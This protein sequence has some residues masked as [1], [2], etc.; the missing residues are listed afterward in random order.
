MV[1]KNMENGILVKN[2]AVL[3]WYLQM[4]SLIGGNSKIKTRKDME[5]SRMQMDADTSVN[6]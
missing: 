5:H 6:S 2:M 3:R 1:N 4:V